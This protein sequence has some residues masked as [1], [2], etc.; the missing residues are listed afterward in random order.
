MYTTCSECVADVYVGVKTHLCNIHTC[1][2][3][4]AQNTCSKVH[5]TLTA[6]KCT[7]IYTYTHMHTHTGALWHEHTCAC[8]TPSTSWSTDTETH[9][10]CINMHTHTYTHVYKRIHIH[11]HTHMHIYI[12]IYTCP[13]TY[14]YTHIYTHTYKIYI[15]T[16]ASTPGTTARQQMREEL[17]QMQVQALHVSF[18]RRNQTTFNTSNA[19]TSMYPLP[20]TPILLNPPSPFPHIPQNSSRTAGKRDCTVPHWSDEQSVWLWRSSAH[21]HN[22]PLRSC[23]KI[24]GKV[25][26][27]QNPSRWARRTWRPRMTKVTVPGET[28][29]QWGTAKPHNSPSRNHDSAAPRQRPFICTG[30]EPIHPVHGP[31]KLRAHESML[32]NRIH[33]FAIF[34]LFHCVPEIFLWEKLPHGLITAWRLGVWIPNLGALPII[35]SV[36]LTHIPSVFACLHESVSCLYVFFSTCLSVCVTVAC[37]VFRVL[38]HLH[39][40]VTFFNFKIYIYMTVVASVHI[41]FFVLLY[42]FHQHLYSCVCVLP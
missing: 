14:T 33:I 39:F 27:Q 28:K 30:A 38:F 11:I 26:M 3:T 37:C 8:M 1:P 18:V 2:C 16:H 13:R 34:W 21:L 22:V 35:A 29:R 4:S 12:Y 23:R 20:E 41:S 25:A 19:R 9:N 17:M 7:Y 40:R 15:C 5:A 31:P 24:R 36:S 32:R 42:L 6:K 10:L